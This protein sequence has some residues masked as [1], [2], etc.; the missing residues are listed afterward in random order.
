ML[1]KNWNEMTD[2]G[3]HVTICLFFFFLESNRTEKGLDLLLVSYKVTIH[4]TNVGYK[5][6][7]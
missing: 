7:R 1:D 3:G 6:S 5:T 2:P 4:R